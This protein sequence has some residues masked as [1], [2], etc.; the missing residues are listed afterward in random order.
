MTTLEKHISNIA[1]Y[2]THRI[3]ALLT[4]QF[5]VRRAMNAIAMK[6]RRYGIKEHKTVWFRTATGV[7]VVVAGGCIVPMLVEKHLSQYPRFEQV[8]VL[9]EGVGT[10]RFNETVADYM[11][12]NNFSVYSFASSRV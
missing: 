1:E 10:K 4:G 8:E 2:G 11:K 3:V 5:S 7:V 6:L 12:G 9:Y